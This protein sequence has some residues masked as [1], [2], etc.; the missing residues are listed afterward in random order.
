M[1]TKDHIETFNKINPTQNLF[2][3]N[4]ESE[5]LEKVYFLIKNEIYYCQTLLVNKMIE[6]GY[7]FEELCIDVDDI[8]NYSVSS[9]DAILQDEYELLTE[10]REEEY[11]EKTIY[12]W[13]LISDNLA[14]RIENAGGVVVYSVYGTWW[15]RE[16]TG[17]SLK[18]DYILNTVVDKC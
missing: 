8:V 17:Q 3:N 13:W 2:E 6:R 10:M 18:F 12:E 1:T 15:G 9:N 5:R 16:E 4:S 11:I 7:E 14:K